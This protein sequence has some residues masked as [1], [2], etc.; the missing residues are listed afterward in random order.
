M[1]LICIF[2]FWIA[3]KIID[4][5]ECN[6]WDDPRCHDPFNYTI[7]KKD[8]PPLRDCE[9]CC[10]KMVQ[11]IGTGKQFTSYYFKRGWG[12]SFQF[13]EVSKNDQKIPTR[14]ECYSLTLP[15]SRQTKTI[16]SIP[17]YL[18]AISQS[19][20]IFESMESKVRYIFQNSLWQHVISSNSSV[21]II[22]FWIWL[23]SS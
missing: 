21:T 10:V 3:G 11:F 23:A 14:S 6:S 15:K 17:F 18:D 12:F 2:S 19:C 1:I 4:C 7:H 20:W 16:I 22:E 8:M 9:G 5:F 13:S